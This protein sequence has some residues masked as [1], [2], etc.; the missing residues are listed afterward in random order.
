M[1]LWFVPRSKHYP[2]IKSLHGQEACMLEAFTRAPIWGRIYA[3]R[4]LSLQEE[5]T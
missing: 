2:R 1:V 3:F 5:P 4:P